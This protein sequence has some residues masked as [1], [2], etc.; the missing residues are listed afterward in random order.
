MATAAQIAA[1]QRNA[2]KSTGPKT[3]LGKAKSSRN[4]I[5]HG[6]TA[7][8][9]QEEVLTHLR[10]IT[11]DPETTV[12]TC[13]ETPLGQAAIEL[14]AAEAYLDRVRRTVAVG[15]GQ[16]PAEALTRPL[17]DV[18]TMLCGKTEEKQLVRALGQFMDFC[19]G[20][21][22]EPWRASPASARRYYAAAHVARRK[23][24]RRFLEVL[25]LNYKTNP[26]ST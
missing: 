9:E 7:A 5:S 26:I 19:E 10:N 2:L 15:Y 17:R 22:S 18:L 12:E 16:D 14:A 25:K 4:A 6:L 8:T 20:A 21:A 13:M 23:A 11:G 1:N 3:V 24:L